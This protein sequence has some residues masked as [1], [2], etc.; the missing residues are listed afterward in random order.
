MTPLSR[1]RFLQA[2]LAAMAAGLGASSLG[3][4]TKKPPNILFVA[5]DD[6]NDWVGCLGGYPGKIHTPNIDSLAAGGTLFTNAHCAI[7]LCN[8]SRT[9]TL[10]GL[11][12]L[13]TG[14]FYN[15][16]HWRELATTKN[17]TP[18]PQLFRNHGYRA[19]GSGKI[20]HFHDPQSWDSF[21]PDTLLGEPKDIREPDYKN[22]L[23]G[24]PQSYKMD[25]TFDWG[26]VDA[27][28]EKMPDYQISEWVIHQLQMA[29]PTQPLFIGY[30][31]GKPHLPWYLPQQYFDRY[32][33][34]EVQLP[35]VLQNDLD[36]VPPEGRK[37]VNEY[38]HNDVVRYGFWKKAI[39]AYLA[40]ITFADEQLGRVLHAL[41]TSPVADNTI[42]VLWSDHGWHLGE[43]MQ[44]RK[45]TLWQEATHI[46]L[47][48]N[49]PGITAGQRCHAP[50][51]LL[52]IYPTL[53]D[54]THLPLPYAVDGH[55]VV[56]L[57]HNAAAAWPNKAFTVWQM[58]GKDH[59]AVVDERYRFIRYADGSEELYDHT[60]DPHEWYNI[61]NQE[62]YQTV[63]KTLSAA[64]DDYITRSTAH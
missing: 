34:S 61:V 22:T 60:K 21:W 5:F 33:L 50:V 64:I 24:K 4:S 59:V 43:K 63:R 10:T 11:S 3:G 32:P 9:S 44:W 28:V 35:A 18:I 48:F 2:S 37:L 38:L 13:R 57:L 25:T 39:Q 40:S 1:R 14:A 36:D 52:D 51:S 16:T 23:R 45:L 26:A 42:V 41:R 53:A 19:V 29:S 49:G 7:P 8:G 30:G 58:H 56:P 15:D 6:L 55:S 62:A 20:F 17:A 47:I 31:I 27:P 54:L 12:P 46:P